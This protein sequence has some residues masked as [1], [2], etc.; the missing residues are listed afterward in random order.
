MVPVDGV[1]LCYSDLGLFGRAGPS[2]K[3]PSPQATASCR[4]EPYYSLGAIVLSQF[5]AK[6]RREIMAYIETRD[7]WKCQVCGKVPPSQRRQ[8]R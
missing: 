5:T 4:S 7:G 1:W 6:Q 2:G 3:A 8:G